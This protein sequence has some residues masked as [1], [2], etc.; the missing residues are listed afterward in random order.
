MYANIYFL[1]Q[2]YSAEEEVTG[3]ISRRHH[4]Q[5]TRLTFTLSYTT[6]NADSGRKM[7]TDAWSKDLLNSA[8]PDILKRPGKLQ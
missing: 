1:Y 6:S 4:L 5:E 3:C 7:T 2:H 8:R